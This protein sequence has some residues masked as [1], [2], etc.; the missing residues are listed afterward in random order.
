MILCFSLRFP[1][2]GE[3]YRPTTSSFPISAIMIAN[4][5]LCSGSRIA[6]RES[7]AKN[8]SVAIFFLTKE[9]KPTTYCGNE[10]CDRKL[11][12]YTQTSRLQQRRGKDMAAKKAKKKKR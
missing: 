5:S 12:L 8:P 9:P 3:K 2:R 6:F 4:A 11:W 7:E 10:V 1:A